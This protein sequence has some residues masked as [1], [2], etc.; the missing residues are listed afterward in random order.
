MLDAIGYPAPLPPYS[1]LVKEAIL[2]DAIHRD[3]NWRQFILETAFFYIGLMPTS[4]GPARVS[5]ANIGRTMFET[6]P[7]TAAKGQTPWVGVYS[8]S[9]HIFRLVKI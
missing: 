4:E 9:I 2:S 1:S 8:M 5:Y 3:F 7:V 6:Y